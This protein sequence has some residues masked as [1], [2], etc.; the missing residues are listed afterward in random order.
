MGHRQQDSF[1][2]FQ[3]LLNGV[4][5]ELHSPAHSSSSSSS[6]AS[7]SAA[8]SLKV[9]YVAITDEDPVG[10]KA[11]KAW[12]N[13]KLQSSSPLATLFTGLLCNTITCLKCG[14]RSS[15]FDPHGDVS[16]EIPSPRA[17]L[18]SKGR[19]TLTQCLQEFTKTEDLASEAY[20]CSKCKCKRDA[21]KQLTF[22]RLPPVL[23]VHLK[24]FAV[25]DGLQTSQRAFMRESEVS[26]KISTDVK[27]ERKLNLSAFMSPDAPGPCPEYSLVGTVNHVQYRGLRHYVAYTRL[28]HGGDYDWALFDDSSVSEVSEKH[29]MQQRDSAY[30]LFYQQ[31]PPQR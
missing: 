21:S 1:E 10:L 16:L 25:R 18:L 24:R 23:V 13:F 17:K 20:L 11:A 4:L 22:H 28:C 30:M 2:F 26:T 29:V 27:F 8:S 3:L 9:P 14:T 19:V 6:S 15:T 7:S 31:D 12:H 5:D